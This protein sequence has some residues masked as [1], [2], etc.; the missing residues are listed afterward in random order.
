[1]KITVRPIKGESFFVEVP[2]TDTIESLKHLAD[3]QLQAATSSY[4][5]LQAAS[6]CR[7]EPITKGYKIKV[8]KQHKLVVCIEGFQC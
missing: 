2:E 5:Q 3:K 6:K 8:E 7:H 1:M 4:K